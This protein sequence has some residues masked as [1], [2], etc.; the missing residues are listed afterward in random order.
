MLS[1]S[2]K[3]TDTLI[4]QHEMHTPHLLF[5]NLRKKKS[6]SIIFEPTR[7]RWALPLM[8]VHLTCHQCSAM[9]TCIAF[10]CATH[11]FLF[12]SHSLPYAPPPPFLS[13]LLSSCR[14]VKGLVEANKWASISKLISLL[15]VRVCAFV[16][17]SS[18]MRMLLANQAKKII[19]IYIYI[20]LSFQ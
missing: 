15:Q 11:N 14:H 6:H 2:Q 19:Y 3:S 5:V 10:P 9:C 13:L 4:Q 18:E 20:Y 16:S 8:P 7:L 12:P 17:L 1:P